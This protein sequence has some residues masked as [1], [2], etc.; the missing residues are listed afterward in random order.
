MDNGKTQKFWEYIITKSFEKNETDKK[1]A[2]CTHNHESLASNRQETIM[3]LGVRAKR[4]IANVK[5]DSWDSKDENKNKNDADSEWK[6]PMNW[7]FTC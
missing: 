2:N 3:R 5:V 6:K 4:A 1:K 7:R